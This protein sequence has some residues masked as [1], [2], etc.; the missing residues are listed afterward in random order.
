MGIRACQITGHFKTFYPPAWRVVCQVK[1]PLPGS[2]NKS[3]LWKSKIIVQCKSGTLLINKVWNSDQMIQ[4]PNHFRLLVKPLPSPGGLQQW[5]SLRPGWRR[6]PGD[7]LDVF[8]V[9][10]LTLTCRS[11]PLRRRRATWPG[12][13]SWWTTS[14]WSVLWWWWTFFFY[15]CSYQEEEEGASSAKQ[16]TVLGIHDLP[17]LQFLY[18]TLVVLSIMLPS[19]KFSITNPSSW[20]SYSPHQCSLSWHPWFKWNKKEKT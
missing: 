7:I 16:W 12:P 5:S 20:T 9:S 17:M 4:F 11:S 15:D 8:F 18:R 1:S 14:P 2:T 10:V 13:S 3:W 6:L 19:W